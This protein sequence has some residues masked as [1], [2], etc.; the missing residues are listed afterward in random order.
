MV[1]NSGNSFV[2]VFDTTVRNATVSLDVVHPPPMILI[3]KRL[4]H[5]HIG[6]RF[7]GDVRYKYSTSSGDIWP[8]GL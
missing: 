6:K 1:G 8:F 5:N 7:N 4:G 2:F 3:V